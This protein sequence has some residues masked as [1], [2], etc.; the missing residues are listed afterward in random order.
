[1][2]DLPEPSRVDEA[3]GQQDKQ[4]HLQKIEDIPA[5]YRNHPR[6]EELSQDPAHKGDTPGK[7][8]REAMSAL[9]AEMSG[10]VKGPVTRG[11][12]GYIDFY[13]GEGYPFDVKTPLSPVAKDKWEFSPYQV[14][15][16]VLEQLDQTHKNKF[17]DEEQPV[18]V[19]LDTTYMSQ[20]D[21]IE[22]WRELRRMTKENRGILK[23]IFEVNVKLDPEQKNKEAPNKKALSPK[24][25]ALLSQRLC[26]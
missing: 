4:A 23:R 14:A 3:A 13:D 19:L 15:D 9:E 5:R 2:L 16:K 25:M 12:D 26:R 1:M 21:R 10:K 7:V 17:T 11:D 24:Q 18:A 8:L 22:M 20:K 6:F